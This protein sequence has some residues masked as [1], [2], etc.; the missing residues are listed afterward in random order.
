MSGTKLS[1]SVCKSPLK[2]CSVALPDLYRCCR[3]SMYC[4]IVI[5][6][7]NVG[8]ANIQIIKMFAISA[9]PDG[10]AGNA[11]GICEA[12]LF[13]RARAKKY[14]YC[15]NAMLCKGCFRKSLFARGV[16]AKVQNGSFI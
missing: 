16:V 9:C 12:G 11:R 8:K 7:E 10:L 2:V 3:L 13:K 15:A 14:S 4:C 6:C 5:Y 1:I